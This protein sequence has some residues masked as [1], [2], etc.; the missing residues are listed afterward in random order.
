MSLR[1]FSSFALAASLVVFTACEDK[2][3]SDV[4]T[5]SND[6]AKKP[7]VKPQAAGNAKPSQKPDAFKGFRYEINET[8]N[9]KKCTTGKREFATFEAYCKGLLDDALNKNCARETREE[10]YE[11]AGCGKL[12]NGANGVDFDFGEDDEAASTFGGGHGDM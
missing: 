11:A 12:E 8:I 4:E 2:K 7:G 1:L 5:T 3:D 6:G 10:T 9:G